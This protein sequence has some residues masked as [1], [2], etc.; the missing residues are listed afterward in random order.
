MGEISKPTKERLL[1]CVGPSPSS[2]DVIRAT[3]KLAAQLNAEWFAVYV[4]TPRMVRLPEADQ[5]RALQNLQLAEHLGAET[6]TLFSRNMAEKIGDFARR[7]N[8]TK[9]IAGKPNHYRWQDILF[10]SDVDGLVRLSGEIDVYFTT[11]EPEKQ[12]GYL[13][14]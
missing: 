5:N 2:A 6:F 13:S 12:R 1:V 11:G 10:G 8:I 4:K 3:K 7:H 14:R 9:I